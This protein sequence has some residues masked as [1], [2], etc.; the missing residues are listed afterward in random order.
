MKIVKRKKGQFIVLAALIVAVMIVSI[1]TIMYGTIMYFRH[2]RWQEYLMII[3]NVELGSQ[4]VIEISLANYTSTFN[5]QIL[6]DNLN[7]W[8]TNL[9]KAYPG[10][11]VALTYF[12]D[13]IGI[14]AE[15]VT[16]QIDE[17]GPG[18]Y[19]NYFSNATATLNID[20]TSV[21]LT[22]YRFIASAFLG[23][24]LNVESNDGNNLTISIAV[25][26]EDGTPVTNLD[27]DNFLIN[28]K[29][30]DNFQNSKLT[31]EYIEE[32]GLIRIVYNIVASGV[33]AQEVAV[34]DH[35]DI[36]VIAPI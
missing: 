29:T 26:K 31:H 12:D 1:G 8:Q 6:T 14:D 30:L 3:D 23:V 28:N 32:N 11:G 22:G 2:E 5:P 20:M 16:A 25:E 27:T 36:K 18:E 35:R 13:T 17:T 34:V 19:T 33:Q 21:G 4:R 9:T 24:I 7:Q 10:L 15:N